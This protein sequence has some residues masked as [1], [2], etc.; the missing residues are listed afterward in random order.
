[1]ALFPGS[2]KLQQ[3]VAGT[4]VS[5]AAFPAF[6]NLQIFLILDRLLGT[7]HKLL[8]KLYRTMPT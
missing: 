6:E 8:Q 7:E 3:H 2:L 5:V 4:F 1:M